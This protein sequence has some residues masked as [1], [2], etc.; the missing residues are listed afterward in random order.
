MT[1]TEQERANKL[2]DFD[3][4]IYINLL[5]ICSYEDIGKLV[6]EKLNK[7]KSGSKY[8]ARHIL[9]AGS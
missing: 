9:I 4:D 1:T 2:E 6:V 5:N 7:T 8:G 3:N